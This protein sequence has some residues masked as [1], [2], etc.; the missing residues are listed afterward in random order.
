MKP[1]V[2]TSTQMECKQFLDREN[3]LIRRQRVRD[4]FMAIQ[5]ELEVVRQDFKL[6]IIRM[7][8]LQ[9]EME[10]KKSQYSEHLSSVIILPAN[11]LAI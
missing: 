1:R 8:S 9:S 3:Q 7:G 6:V 5:N 4:R 11:Y 10:V 2:R